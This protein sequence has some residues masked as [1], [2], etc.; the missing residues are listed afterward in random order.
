MG[1]WLLFIYGWGNKY[2]EML[3]NMLIEVAGLFFCVQVYADF[4]ASALEYLSD[5]H[6]F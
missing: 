2:L 4:K 6:L 1:K 3:N 5:I